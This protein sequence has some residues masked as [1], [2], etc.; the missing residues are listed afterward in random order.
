M[1]STPQHFLNTPAGD[2]IPVYAMDADWSEVGMDVMAPIQA[3]SKSWLA[4]ASSGFPRTGSV[5]P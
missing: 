3:E 5:S 2:R 4:M 1:T